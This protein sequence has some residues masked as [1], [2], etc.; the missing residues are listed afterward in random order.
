MNPSF[1][2]LGRV[3]RTDNLVSIQGAS[4]LYG[5]GDGVLT[6]REKPL[7]T[8]LVMFTHLPDE[9]QGA[10]QNSNCDDAVTTC[11]CVTWSLEL[12]SEGFGLALPSLE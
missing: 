9:T 2:G 11:V 8:M 6:E 3:S 12:G 7:T 5:S 1:V 10:K 4:A